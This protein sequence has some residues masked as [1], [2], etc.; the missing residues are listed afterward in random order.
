MSLVEE[1]IRTLVRKVVTGL[2]SQKSNVIIARNLVIMHM[3]DGRSN[4][5]KEGKSKT[6]QETTTLHREQCCWDVNPHLN[7]MMF[8]KFHVTYAI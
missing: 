5:T 1:R 6:N 3:N 8:K 7:V 4:M 2:I